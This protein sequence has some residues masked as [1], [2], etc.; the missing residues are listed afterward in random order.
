MKIFLVYMFVIASPCI[1]RYIPSLQGGMDDSF[2]GT[3]FCERHDRLIYH[4]SDELLGHT[5]PYIQV[6]S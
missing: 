5:L 2:K 4:C 3:V 1:Q 6:N